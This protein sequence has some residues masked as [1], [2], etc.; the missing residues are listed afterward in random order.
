MSK[1]TPETIAKG[2]IGED[3]FAICVHRLGYSARR[4]SPQEQQTDAGPLPDF[5]LTT[6]G[7][8]VF[9]AEIKT[10]AQ[11]KIQGQVGSH[12]L[13]FCGKYELNRIS[14]QATSYAEWMKK[15]YEGHLL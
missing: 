12:L 2:N 11:H 5:E 1:P 6:A 7:G 10:Q 8:M 15:G 14:E 13:K 3:A 9:D 4:R